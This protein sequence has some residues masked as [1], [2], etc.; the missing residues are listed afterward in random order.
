MQRNNNLNL[1]TSEH[2]W[3]QTQSYNSKLMNLQKQILCSYLNTDTGEQSVV[4]FVYSAQ[5]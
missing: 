2:S 3:K 1:D 5:I 4:V